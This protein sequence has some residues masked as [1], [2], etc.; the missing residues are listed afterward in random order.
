MLFMACVCV[1][2]CV[3]V[4]MQSALFSGAFNMEQVMGFFLSGGGKRINHHLLNAYLSQLRVRAPSPPRT[5]LP[6]HTLG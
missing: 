6:D 2:M 3:W 1:C 4:G 5:L